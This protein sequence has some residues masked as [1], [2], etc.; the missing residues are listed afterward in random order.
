M[1]RISMAFFISFLGCPISRES[2]L[3]VS[4]VRR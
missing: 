1:K 4:R 3:L 2:K